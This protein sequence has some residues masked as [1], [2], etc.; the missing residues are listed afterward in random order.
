[1]ASLFGGGG[2]GG[3]GGLLGGIGGGGGDAPVAGGEI[4]GATPGTD[5]TALGEYMSTPGYQNASSR[6]RA[7][8]DA[9]AQESM[10]LDPNYRVTQ[11]Q[12]R[13]PDMGLLS[14]GTQMGMDQSGNGLQGLLAMMRQ[15]QR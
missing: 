8:A 10:G 6:N 5:W 9:A 3:I 4:P 12:R 2:E 14:R 15:A 11:I 7:G 1:M 13:P